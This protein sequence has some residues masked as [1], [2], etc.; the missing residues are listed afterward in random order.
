MN[1]NFKANSSGY[2]IRCG[3]NLKSIVMNNFLDCKYIFTNYLAGNVAIN[4]AYTGEIPSNVNGGQ[5]IKI[6]L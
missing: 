1:N 3:T 6:T 2:L 5:N 4:N